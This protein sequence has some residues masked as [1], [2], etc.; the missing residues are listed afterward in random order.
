MEFRF[1]AEEWE[2]LTPAERIKRCHKMAGEA[3]KLARNAEGETKTHF[4]R[5]A[6][7][8][9]QLGDEIERNSN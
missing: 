6:Q 4:L 5:I 1:N 8:W 3:R 9:E 7:D 2:T